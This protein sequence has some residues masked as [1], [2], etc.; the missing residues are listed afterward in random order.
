MIRV[1]NRVCTAW[2]LLTLWCV[3]VLA[4]DPS[5]VILMYH[6]FGESAFPSTSTTLD[7]L[8]DHIRALEDGGHAVLPLAHVIAALRHG[9][10]LPDK[11][12]AITVD[13]AYR[14]F[15]TEGWP[16]FKAT[17]FPV[18][19]F[20]ATAGVD[21]GFADLLTWDDI[22]SLQ[23]E[24]IAVGAHSHG[25][26]HYPAMSADAVEDDLQMMTESFV[27]AL[28]EV[29]ALFAFPYGEAG[30]A[31]ITAVAEAGFTAAFGQHSGAAG[32]T[33]EP[34][35]LPRFALNEAFGGPDR[36][37]LVIN[38]V[39]L[40]VVDMEPDEPVLKDNPP[41]F[42]LTLSA[43]PQ[44]IA[45]L[46]CFGP[47]GTPLETA[48]DG[49]AVWITPVER[50]PTGRVRLNCT[51]PVRTPGLSGRWYWFGWQMIAGFESEGAAVHP[52]YR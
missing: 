8:D 6:R 34:F 14:S 26:G 17:G 9:S 40:P 50:F 36:F 24:G 22:R 44:N 16:R 33:S 13:D 2:G 25:H 37:R 41:V 27:Q 12:V 30:R 4:G 46:T 43:P 11:A 29:P 35:Y 23:D 1:F 15:L 18:T 49:N 28:G 45:A 39:P 52:R 19:L 20:V 10:P 48:V 38:T 47:G 5:A 21:A 31:D 32:V 7:Q 42:A 3:P 51:L